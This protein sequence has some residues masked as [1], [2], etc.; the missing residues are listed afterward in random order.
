MPRCLPTTIDPPL[1]PSF[2]PPS[3]HAPSPLRVPCPRSW[4]APPCAATGYDDEHYDYI[5]KS[6]EL[7]NEPFPG[8]VFGVPGLRDNRVAD[9]RNLQPFYRNVTAA[10]RAAVPDRSR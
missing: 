1:A 7:F 8:D 3:S 2:T 10:I 5:V 4:S 9:R 6:G